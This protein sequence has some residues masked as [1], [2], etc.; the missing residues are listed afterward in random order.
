[1]FVPLP[2]DII[3]NVIG[4][5]DRLIEIGFK[6]SDPL[7]PATTR[8]FNERNLFDEKLQSDWIKSD[9]TIRNIFKACFV[10]A[11]FEYLKPHSFRKTIARYAQ[12][13]SPEFLNAVRQNLGHSSIDTTLSSYGQL[14]ELDQRRVITDLRTCFN[15]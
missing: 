6:S 2:K 5:R 10:N 4:W 14:S 15:K 9:T 13:Q 12:T 3:E 1:V 8:K 11:G 7:F